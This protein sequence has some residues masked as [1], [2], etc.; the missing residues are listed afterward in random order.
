MKDKGFIV[1]CIITAL[2][3][4][5]MIPILIHADNQRELACQKLGFEGD[6]YNGNMRYCEDREGNLHY[7]EMECEPWYWPDCTAKTIS[8]GEVRVK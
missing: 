3:F 5:W 8:V 1:V 7:I 6:K 4:I 2:Y